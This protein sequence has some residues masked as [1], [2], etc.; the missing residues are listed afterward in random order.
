MVAAYLMATSGQPWRSVVKAVKRRRAIA[1]PNAGFQR[2]LASFDGAAEA[3]EL[4]C[5]FGVVDACGDA[6]RVEALHREFCVGR[7]REEAEAPFWEKLYL[8]D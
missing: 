5:T 6:S 7:H 8:I 4:A 2:Q 3:M 1:Q